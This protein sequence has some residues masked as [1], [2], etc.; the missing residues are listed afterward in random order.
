MTDSTRSTT[1][2]MA[3]LGVSAGLALVGIGVFG[4][5]DPALYTGLS[6]MVPAV[7]VGSFTRPKR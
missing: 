6:I 7:G 5:S 4:N 2:K 1:F 3:L